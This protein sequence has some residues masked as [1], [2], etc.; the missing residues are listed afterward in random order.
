MPVAPHLQELSRHESL[1]L[2][3][4]APLGRVEVSIDALPVVL[5]VLIVMVDDRIVFRTVPGTKLTAATQG[6]IV[7]VEADDLDERTG[8]GWTVLVRGIAL[9]VTDPV[10]AGVARA[11]LGTSWIDGAPEHLVEV[12]TDLVTGRRLG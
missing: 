11:R 7:A 3:G 10:L 8:Q 1:S 9:E 6:A 2:L 5:P 12:T 4:G